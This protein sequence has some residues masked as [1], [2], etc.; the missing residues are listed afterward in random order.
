[1]AGTRSRILAFLVWMLL[2]SIMANVSVQ[3]ALYHGRLLKPGLNRRGLRNWTLLTAS[4]PVVWTLAIIATLYVSSAI[5]LALMAII[6]VM[7]LQEVPGVGPEVPMDTP[8]EE[9]VSDLV[10]APGGGGPG[11]R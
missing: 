3:A 1:M 2:L 10:E 7:F 6:L 8:G 9:D 11:R 5:A 4:G